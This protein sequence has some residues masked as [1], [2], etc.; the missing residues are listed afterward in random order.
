M[1]MRRLN[2][3][4]STLNFGELMAGTRMTNPT[5][6]ERGLSGPTNV[7]AN[8]EVVEYMQYIR[9]Y[10]NVDGYA[11]QINFF[12]YKVDPVAKAAAAGPFSGL[13]TKQ[14]SLRDVD[15]RQVVRVACNCPEY[16]FFFGPANK[17]SDAHIG[18]LPNSK[19]DPRD[20]GHSSAEVN[21][22]AVPGVCQHL[23]ALYRSLV[24]SHRVVED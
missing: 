6:F 11:P 17:I 19:L 7:R 22:G 24:K 21:L 8:S 10:A 12:D 15:S 1:I 3:A 2:E 20:Y 18:W 14:A 5:E 23:I 9:F 13:L 16:K 4:K